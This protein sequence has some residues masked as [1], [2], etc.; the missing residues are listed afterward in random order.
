MGVRDSRIGDV[1]YLLKGLHVLVV[2]N[3]TCPDVTLLDDDSL[4]A[5]KILLSLQYGSG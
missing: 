1:R 2:F 4:A 5:L 3:C